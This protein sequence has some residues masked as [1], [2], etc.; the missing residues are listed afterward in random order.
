ML[1]N[2]HVR[3][4][5]VILLVGKVEGSALQPAVPGPGKVHRH[6][7]RSPTT[8]R[9]TDTLTSLR[10]VG[11]RWGTDSIFYSGQKGQAIVSRVEAWG[12]GKAQRVETKRTGKYLK[13]KLQEG[14][15]GLVRING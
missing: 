12:L 9:L 2:I 4:R 14:E 5:C 15:Q 11:Y 6:R 8:A 13:P 7:C 3:R 10:S 1:G